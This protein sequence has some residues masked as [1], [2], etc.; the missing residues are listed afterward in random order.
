VQRKRLLKLLAADAFAPVES[1]GDAQG[2]HYDYAKLLADEGDADGA[3]A[4]LSGLKD[5]GL[6]A[7]ALFD[8]HLRAFLPKDFDLR[9]S[10]EAELALDRE[11]SA[12][13]PDRLDPLLSVAS[14]LRRLGRPGEALA[15]LQ[16]AS[17]KIGDKAAFTDRDDKLSWYWDGLARA[18]VALGRYDDAISAFRAGAALRENGQP[19][20]SQVI[21]LAHTQNRFGHG[22]DALKTL[23]LFD[24]PKQPLS[25]YGMMEMRL[26]R[27]CAQAV[28][29]HAAAGA[30]DLAY[31]VAHEKD[32]P[33]A[34]GDLYLCLGRMDEAAASY[35]R[36]L[37]D[38]DRRSAALRQL[39]DYDAPPVAIPPTPFGARL[40]ALKAR[41]DVKSAIARAGGLRRI[42]LQIDDL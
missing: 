6:L 8:P 2:L 34:L 40:E 39:S 7:A 28:S 41:P 38:P 16:A 5:P 30:A 18:Y 20:V 11:L 23:S 31:A 26:A 32:H 15:I 29:G 21:N 35:I 14:D 24:D 9:A 13:H 33:E 37:D 36:L 17:S 12:R 25:P 1:S 3:R 4:M 27:G 22:E 10:A 19:N 42:P